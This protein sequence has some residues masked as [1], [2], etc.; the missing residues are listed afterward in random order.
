MT[1]IAGQGQKS[2][3]SFHHELVVFVS[4]LL[5]SSSIAQDIVQEA[6][7]RYL[8]RT[9]E[10]QVEN[11]RA[12]LYRIASNLVFDE[13]RRGARR[14]RTLVEGAEVELV[15]THDP[16]PTR[17]LSAKQELELLRLAVEELPPR[18]REVF[19][20]RKFDQLSQQEIADRLGI[21]R[22]MVE[23]HLRKGLLHCRQRLIDF[24]VSI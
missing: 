2:V 9:S 18:C 21:S 15:A 12:F 6:Y 8:R 17:V 13:R 14:E 7:A 4:R 10:V 19:Q 22:N 11:P 5:G 16:S 1:E 24:G 3:E 20:L 23:K